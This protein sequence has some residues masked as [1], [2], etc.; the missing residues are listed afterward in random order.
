MKK[1][2]IVL[3]S[4][5]LL[6]VYLP[7]SAKDKN[8]ILNNKKSNYMSL[9]EYLYSEKTEEDMKNLKLNNKGEVIYKNKIILDDN[10]NSI[11]DETSGDSYLLL[12]IYLV[13]SGAEPK[14]NC[15]VSDYYKNGIYGLGCY[16]DIPDD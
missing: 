12:K 9:S 4:I 15:D 14:E 6:L 16:I 13:A 1:F 11:T 5:F 3:I 8:V 7:S 2:V 10:G